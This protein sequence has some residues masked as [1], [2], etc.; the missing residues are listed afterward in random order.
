[1]LHQ[2]ELSEE[3]WVLLKRCA[4]PFVDKDPE[5]TV[6]R[7]LE[8]YERTAGNGA[9]PATPEST[10]PTGR[11][12]DPARRAPRERGVA[13]ELDGLRIDAVSVR[14]MYEQALKMLVENHEARLKAL[15]PF[16]TSRQRFLVAEKPIHPSGNGFVIPVRYRGYSMEAHKDYKNA[17]AHLRQLA[18]RIGV[19]VRYLA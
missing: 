12:R 19:T 7:A 5:D 3:T 9:K 17:I 10:G 8:V 13:L 6:R 14:D 18:D 15:L 4:E 11:R 2:V 16:R 1:M